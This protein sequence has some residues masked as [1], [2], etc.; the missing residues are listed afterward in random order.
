MPALRE[1]PGNCTSCPHFPD[2]AWDETMIL[3]PSNVK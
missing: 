2:P 3:G 1:R